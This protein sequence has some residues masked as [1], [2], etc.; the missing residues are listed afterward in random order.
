MTLRHAKAWRKTLASIVLTLAI[1]AAMDLG[2]NP[3]KTLTFAKD[4]HLFS[5]IPSPSRFNR[6]FHVLKPYLLALLPLLSHL[7]QHQHYAL[8]TFPIPVCPTI[9]TPAPS[10]PQAW[11]TAATS[12]AS[13]SISMVTSC[14]FG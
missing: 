4:F 5:Y 3:K 9:R 12:P 10:W 14:T 1:L 2:G 7:W 6:R 11:C 13:G 8:D